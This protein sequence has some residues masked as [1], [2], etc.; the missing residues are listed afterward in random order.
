MIE[1]NL[2]GNAFTHLTSGNK[3]YS[4]HGKESKYIKWVFDLSLIHI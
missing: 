2:Y 3:G 1:C 4:T